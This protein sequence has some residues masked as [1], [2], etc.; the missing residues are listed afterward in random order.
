MSSVIIE[1]GVPPVRLA[2]TARNYRLAAALALG[3]VV[4]AIGFAYPNSGTSS[5]F[6]DL[7]VPQIVTISGP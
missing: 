7:A 5:A 2:A 6:I 1:S 4:L 3:A